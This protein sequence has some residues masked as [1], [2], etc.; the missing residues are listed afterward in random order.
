[1]R[2]PFAGCT[3]IVLSDLPVILILRVKPSI[4]TYFLFVKSNASRMPH[5]NLSG[6]LYRYNLWNPDKSPKP[7]IVLSL[8]STMFNL[9]FIDGLKRLYTIHNMRINKRT[10]NKVIKLHFKGLI[11]SR[12]SPPIPM[13]YLFPSM[14]LIRSRFLLSINFNV[15]STSKSSQGTSVT[16]CSLIGSFDEIVNLLS[17]ILLLLIKTLIAEGKSVTLK[18][19]EEWLF[20]ASSLNC[21]FRVYDKVS[22]LLLD[23]I[24][25]LCHVAL[26]NSI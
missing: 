24:K 8:M 5:L 20:I 13:E 19:A 14:P 15:D 12:T 17:K 10:I 25:S 9:P 26:P 1:M 23:I 11:L 21:G 2:I 6:P 18:V 3:Y 22:G 7:F 4:W 16:N